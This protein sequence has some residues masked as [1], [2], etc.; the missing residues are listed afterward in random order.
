M[1]TG[2]DFVGEKLHERELISRILKWSKENVAI[3]ILGPRRS[4]KTS[5]LKLLSLRF[6]EE[7]YK[8]FYFDLED[9]NDRDIVEGGPDALKRFIG[10]SG[11]VFLDEFHLLSEPTRFVKLCVDWHPEIKLYLTGSS[12]LKILYKAKDSLIGRVIEFRLF[13]LGFREFLTFRGETPYLRLLKR[14]SFEI[15]SFER[16]YIPNRILELLDEYLVFGG[17]PEVVMAETTERKAQLLSQ[18]FRLY[19]LR[20][21]RDA[22]YAVDEI[23]FERVF[24]A[25]AGSTGSPLNLSEIATEVG[26]SLKTVKRYINLL[27]FLFL[28]HRIPPFGANPRTE[29][30]KR[31]K[32][33]LVDSGLLSWTYG[34][35]APRDRLSAIGLQAETAVAISLISRMTPTTRIRY[36]RNKHGEEVDFLWI[37]SGELLPIEVKFQPRQKIPSGL[38]SFLKKYPQHNALVVVRDFYGEELFK[39]TKIHFLPA[40]C[41]L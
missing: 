33:Y 14:F 4:G 40:P 34:S 15:K 2:K 13:P 11:I 16:V 38:R 37:D 39:G 17:F 6:H 29:I 9:P 21:L 26:V 41:F 22:L 24:L 36:W 1:R 3:L 30:K 19:A 10:G 23:A 28:I 12:G 31:Q 32:V 8:T 5:L 18:I 7:G 35:F 25:I 20:D 27:E